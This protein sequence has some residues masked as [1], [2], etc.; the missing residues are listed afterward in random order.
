MLM[1]LF[2]SKLS[3]EAVAETS[4]SLLLFLLLKESAF[5]FGAFTLVLRRL[6]TAFLRIRI[7]HIFHTLLRS[8]RVLLCS[9][10]P[11]EVGKRVSRCLK[12]AACHMDMKAEYDGL[13]AADSLE[14]PLPNGLTYPSKPSSTA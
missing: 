10:I 8:L 5:L 2:K 7:K 6:F 11:K 3:L 14:M 12:H 13:I 1:L 9:D 4:L